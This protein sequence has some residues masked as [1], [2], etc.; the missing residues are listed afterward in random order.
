MSYINIIHNPNLHEDLAH[1]TFI[2][3][4]GGQHALFQIKEL[5]SCQRLLGRR[6]YSLVRG[7]GKM[8]FAQENSQ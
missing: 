7:I 6:H 3:W 1:D 2:E 5:N 4:V 8:H